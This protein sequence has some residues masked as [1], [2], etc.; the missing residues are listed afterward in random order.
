MTKRQATSKAQDL[1]NE[2]GREMF[3]LGIDSRRWF[4]YPLTDQYPHLVPELRKAGQVFSP[5][6]G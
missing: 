1:A 5:K 6:A 4:V 3:I 2:S